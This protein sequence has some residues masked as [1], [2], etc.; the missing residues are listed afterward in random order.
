[1]GRDLV[2]VTL[3]AVGMAASFAAVRRRTPWLM[4]VLGLTGGVS[5]SIKP[6]LMPLAL[7]ALA[8]IILRQRGA[9]TAPYLGWALLGLLAMG[10]VDLGYLLHYGA[11]ANFFFVQR[12]QTTVYAN[13]M[14]HG[15]WMLTTQL[16]SPAM[17]LL[18][19]AAL[20]VAALA[21]RRRPALDWEWGAVL[22]ATAWGLV[23]FYVQGK[24]YLFHRYDYLPFLLLLIGYELLDGLR[25]QGPARWA[26]VAA[27]AFVLLWMLPRSLRDMHNAVG[28][29]VLTETLE[30]DLNTLG[31]TA[32]LQDK[33]LCLDTTF[34]CLDALYQL[35]LLQNSSFTGDLM[36]FAVQSGPMI[37]HYVR[38]FFDQARTDPASVIVVTNSWFIG[39]NSFDKLKQ[40]PEVLAYL[41]QNYT[42]L[43]QRSFPDARRYTGTTG[44]APSERWANA[45]RIYLR[46]PTSATP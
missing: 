46:K 37:D 43:V 22:L 15:V 21:W 42:L 24:G 6:T 19:A 26:A 39:P 3:T 33:V 27:L 14:R 25:R 4:L 11:L 45:Y 38:M 28:Y 16:L 44:E 23:S 41:Q 40:R 18:L 34:G 1:V 32:A 35:R 8:A 9:K 36:F 5:C 13:T 12:L 30:N 17:K 29:S 10:L 7:L 31:G 20:L 2:I